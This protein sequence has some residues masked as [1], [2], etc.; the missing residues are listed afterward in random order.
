MAL[1]DRI[2]LIETGGGF[3]FPCAV[4]L[5]G[6]LTYTDAGMSMRDYFAGQAMQATLSSDT[7][8]AEIAASDMGA[9]RAGL[10][11]SVAEIAYMFADAML[12][13]RAK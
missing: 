12:A 4:K 7:A 13:E 10:A 5:D 6:G 2:N 8:V 1:E 11:K 3:A 9:D